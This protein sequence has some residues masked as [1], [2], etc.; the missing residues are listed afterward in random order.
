MALANSFMSFRTCSSRSSL[1][2]YSSAA[3][4]LCSSRFKYRSFATS[5]ASSRRSASLVLS[6]MLRYYA[7]SRTIQIRNGSHFP[8][9]DGSPSPCFRQYVPS[10]SLSWRPLD[11][12]ELASFLPKAATKFPTHSWDIIAKSGSSVA[13]LVVCRTA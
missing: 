6:S 13:T 3:A 9:W 8:R 2:R 1:S 4:G 12:E 10:S 5:I 7:R 11:R